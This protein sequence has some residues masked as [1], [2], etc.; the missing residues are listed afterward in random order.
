MAGLACADR[1][2]YLAGAIARQ[3]RSALEERANRVA[4]GLTP[5]YVPPLAAEPT[6]AF[7][8]CSKCAH[9]YFG[10]HAVQDA[11]SCA[12]GD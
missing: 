7:A 6:R 10:T 5:E 3:S 11:E 2:P 8:V 12:L 4:I 1:C 9:V